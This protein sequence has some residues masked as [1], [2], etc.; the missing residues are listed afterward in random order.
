MLRNKEEQEQKVPTAELEEKERQ[1]EKQRDA[2]RDT[3]PPSEP[4]EKTKETSTPQAAASWFS[5]F[6]KWGKGEEQ[7]SGERIRQL[8]SRMQELNA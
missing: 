7:P 3:A 8:L 2:T 4:K 6:G 1:A 5:R